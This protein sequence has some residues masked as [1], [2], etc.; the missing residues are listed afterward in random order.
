MM[1]FGMFFIYLFLCFFNK[2]SPRPNVMDKRRPLLV[3][4]VLLL[5]FFYGINGE[6]SITPQ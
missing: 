4:N 1:V 2:H 5:V 3:E 6:T